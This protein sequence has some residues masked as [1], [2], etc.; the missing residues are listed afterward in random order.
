M[1]GA[2]SFSVSEVKGRRR[3][4]PGPNMHSVTGKEDFPPLTI[5]EKAGARTRGAVGRLAH[6]PTVRFFLMRLKL[7][8][9]TGEAVRDTLVPRLT[10]YGYLRLT[11]WPTG[12]RW[13]TAVGPGITRMIVD[14]PNAATILTGITSTTLATRECHEQVLL[15]A[16][17]AI[18]RCVG[19]TNRLSSPRQ[20][21]T[22]RLQ[23]AHDE[24]SFCEVEYI[25]ID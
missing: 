4:I 16:V 25:F 3:K 1:H 18:L 23:M 12:A 6:Y 13:S 11:A 21:N 10:P 9:R 24:L 8:V 2:E 7:L 20:R 19:Q 17:R 5:P 15:S 14:M 22:E